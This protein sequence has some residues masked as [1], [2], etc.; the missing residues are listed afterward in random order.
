MGTKIEQH[1][2][3]VASQELDEELIF[4]RPTLPFGGFFR[5]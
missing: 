3:L 2:R 4:R 1:K 5:G